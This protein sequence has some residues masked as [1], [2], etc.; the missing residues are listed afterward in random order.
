MEH[1]KAKVGN[2]AY[3]L[4]DDYVDDS[5]G[6]L[7][8]ILKYNDYQVPSDDDEVVEYVETEKDTKVKNK[9]RICHFLYLGKGNER[10]E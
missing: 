10:K 7:D 1:L 3:S 5:K 4:G 9:V 2:L 6:I 8:E